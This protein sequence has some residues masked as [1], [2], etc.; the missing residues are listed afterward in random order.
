ME[1]E[2]RRSD[3]EKAEEGDSPFRENFE[4][5]EGFGGGEGEIGM[6]KGGIAEEIV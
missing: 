6:G 2:R 5:A 3:V 4:E 1:R